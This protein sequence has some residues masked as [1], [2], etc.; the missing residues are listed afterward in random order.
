MPEAVTRKLGPLPVWVWALMIGGTFVA[1]RF[2]RGG[3]SQGQDA[4]V[5]MIPT[6]APEIDATAGFLNDLSFRLDSIETAVRDAPTGTKVPPPSTAGG[7]KGYSLT[8]LIN[9]ARDRFPKLR[10][11]WRASDA[12]HLRRG[13]TRDAFLRRELAFYARRRG[14]GIVPVSAKP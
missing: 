2:L 6:G 1:V 5:Q 9:R 8:Q 11:R 7:S 12:G 14:S 4:S 13:E 3:G 10:R